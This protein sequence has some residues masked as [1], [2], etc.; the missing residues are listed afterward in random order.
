MHLFTCVYKHIRILAFTHACVYTHV[1]IHLHILRSLY[2]YA[3]VQ[4]VE[5]C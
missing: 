3:A 5:G 1:H 4:A 2:M